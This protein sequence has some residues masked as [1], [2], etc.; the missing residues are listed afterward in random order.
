MQYCASLETGALILFSYSVRA[1]SLTGIG[2]MLFCQANCLV[3]AFVSLSS[4][5]FICP[6]AFPPSCYP[7][8]RL[9]SPKSLQS[10]FSSS[11]FSPCFPP[12]V[13]LSVYPFITSSFS[14]S[15]LLP[16]ILLVSPFLETSVDMFSLFFPSSL[17]AIF[18]SS[19]LLPS[20]HPSFHSFIPPFVNY[21][22][23]HPSIHP[24]LQHSLLQFPILAKRDFERVFVALSLNLFVIG[25]R[26]QLPDEAFTGPI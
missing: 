4:F 10:I 14:L 24:W 22:S 7:I 2:C 21:P 1:L 19:F 6:S 23:M 3:L 25:R 17:A 15:T 9:P 16:S 11:F 13:L 5:D 12:P 20:L 8:L 26:A 18:L